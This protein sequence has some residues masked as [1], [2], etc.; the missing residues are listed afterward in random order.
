MFAD[1][2]VI[3]YIA[4]KKA[5]RNVKHMLDHYFIISDKLVNYN[6]L[7]VQFSKGMNN[8]K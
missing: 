2:R 4:T 1:D 6:Q 5:K 3:F 7:K 8:I